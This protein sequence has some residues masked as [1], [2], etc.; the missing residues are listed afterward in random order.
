MFLDLCVNSAFSYSLRLEKLACFQ[1]RIYSRH[2][3]YEKDGS[4]KVVN[5][6]T[7]YYNICMLIIYIY[8]SH[9]PPRLPIN[10]LYLFFL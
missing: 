10:H 3:E 1:A 8:Q 5:C 6:T 9:L 4:A 2:R 7:H